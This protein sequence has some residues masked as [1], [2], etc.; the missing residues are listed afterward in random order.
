MNI[1]KVKSLIE[2]LK[3]ALGIDE[4]ISVKIKPMKRKKAS[5]S[6]IKREIRI[7]KNLLPYMSE[8]EVKEVIIHELLHLK[9]GVFH[10]KEFLEDLKKYTA[11]SQGSN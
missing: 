1:E 9:H 8:E 11:L 2:D 10:T 6:L 7:N 3:I 5:I 4:R